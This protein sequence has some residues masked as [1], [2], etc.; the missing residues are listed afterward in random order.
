M[1]LLTIV[2]VLLPFPLFFSPFSASA[3]V[4][5]AS[6]FTKSLDVNS[7]RNPLT[8]DSDGLLLVYCFYQ[9]N[10]SPELVNSADA[11][12]YVQFVSGTWQGRDISELDSPY[13]YNH[14]VNGISQ[15]ISYTD[16]KD[17]FLYSVMWSVPVKSGDSFALEFTY[18][19][20]FVSG[21]SYYKPYAFVPGGTGIK[22]VDKQSGITSPL[23]PLTYTTKSG[24]QHVVTAVNPDTFS[25]ISSSQYIFRSGSSNSTY[26]ASDFENI[27]FSSGSCYA[28]IFTTPYVLSSGSEISFTVKSTV[29]NYSLAVYEIFTDG[30]L[31]PGLDTGEPVTSPTTPGGSGSGGSTDLS[32]VMSYLVRILQAIE[33][34]QISVDDELMNKIDALPDEIGEVF[35]GLFE[36]YFGGSEFPEIT[37]EPPTSSGSESPTFG[38]SSID[39]E[40]FDAVNEILKPDDFSDSIIGQMGGIGFFWAMFDKIITAFDFY[41]VILL[42]LAL[43]LVIWL[44]GA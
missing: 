28:S 30:T 11:L 12:S 21:Q 41:P 19:T 1:V 4:S 29:D 22:L 10:Y 37:T 17:Y 43:S 14:E 39:E 13:F 42:A 18:N 24:N 32:G 40:S 2:I 38:M 6:M 27:L 31:T 23:D 36:E 25:T 3:Y 5:S 16:E 8:F 34:K 26:I 15:V 33:D 7:S 35:R 20:S 9:S 44:I